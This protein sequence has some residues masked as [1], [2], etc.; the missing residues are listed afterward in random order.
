MKPDSDEKDDTLPR[1]PS[2]W[3]AALS[4]LP[5]FPDEEKPKM[6]AQLPRIAAGSLRD[7][8]WDEDGIKT[9]ET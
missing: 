6:P 7:V 1:K 5:G 9:T 4:Q 8:S 3:S 2:S